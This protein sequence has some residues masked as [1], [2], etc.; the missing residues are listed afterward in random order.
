MFC[1][2]VGLVSDALSTT[3]KLDRTS[4]S[5]PPRSPS[6]PTSVT[7]SHS[8]TPACAGKTRKHRRFEKPLKIERY[9]KFLRSNVPKKTN[10]FF[11]C[12][13][14][15]NAFPPL[16]GIHEQELIARQMTAKR[17]S[18]CQSLGP[19]HLTEKLKADRR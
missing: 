17:K 5:D 10:N 11:P 1:T 9:I 12:I 7:P 4:M 6:H 16:F 3:K 13:G 15:K 2:S 8:D 14:G 19:G 18:G